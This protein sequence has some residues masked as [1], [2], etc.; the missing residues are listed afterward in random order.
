MMTEFPSEVLL[1]IFSHLPRSDWKSV[2]LLSKAWSVTGAKQVFDEIR[3]GPS[4]QAMLSL[5]ALSNHEY[6]REIPSRLRI[7]AQLVQPNLCVREFLTRLL[8]QIRLCSS[9]WGWPLS[10]EKT[11]PGSDAIMTHARMPLPLSSVDLVRREGELCANLALRSRYTA[12]LDFVNQQQRWTPSRQRDLLGQALPKL[13]N[14]RHVIFT[15]TWLT[16]ETFKEWSRERGAVFLGL[17]PIQQAPVGDH[18]SE[19]AHILADTFQSVK[20]L[21]LEVN[22]QVTITEEK[23]CFLQRVKKF[24]ARLGPCFR[25]EDAPSLID[26]IGHVPRL[27]TLNVQFYSY[28]GVSNTSFWALQGLL[29]M[30]TCNSTSFT[31]LCLTNAAIFIDDLVNFTQRQPMVQEVVLSDS[32]IV[33]HDGKAGLTV[34]RTQSFWLHR[35][36]LMEPH[37]GHVKV[38]TIFS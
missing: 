14:I 31:R 2:R 22:G 33:Q 30:P 1:Q 9:C 34:D 12:Y 36:S 4:D 21:E 5:T 25:V 11:F 26:L 20:S 28:N 38:S 35:V 16:A 17:D 37:G 10:S 23:S 19:L 24:T 18:L 6:L 15:A 8:R 13:P 7:E 32:V 27:Q 3:M 29:Q